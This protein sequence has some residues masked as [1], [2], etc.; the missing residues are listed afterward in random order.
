MVKFKLI[1][2]N[3]FVILQV[4]MK[5]TVDAFSTTLLSTQ[6]IEIRL[7]VKI[8]N[9]E[10]LLVFVSFALVLSYKQKF[11]NHKGIRKDELNL[12]KF[13]GTDFQCNCSNCIQDVE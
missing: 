5:S 9:V 8:R 13:R 10:P 2:L 1:F 4:V 7:L 3:Q 6:S 11:Y 12:V